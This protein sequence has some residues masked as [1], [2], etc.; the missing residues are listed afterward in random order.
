M[1]QAFH[2][3][4]NE[5]TMFESG[6]F[7][8]AAQKISARIDE[9]R[10]ALAAHNIEPDRNVFAAR[11][12]GVHHA[13]LTDVLSHVDMLKG[14]VLNIH[15]VL[16]NQ[17]VFKQGEG[18]Q[19]HYVLDADQAIEVLSV[20]DDYVTM[21]DDV[22]AYAKGMNLRG[23]DKQMF[24]DRAYHQYQPKEDGVIKFVASHVKRE[25]QPKV[26]AAFAQDS[27]LSDLN[28]HAADMFAEE[29][30]SAAGDPLELT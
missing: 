16:W 19:S 1:D 17:A 25:D 22:R 10:A 4:A 9:T 24:E 3:S 11:T 6:E 8:V 29:L 26:L 18:S 27:R 14:H 15:V 28:M 12:Q 2:S 23:R 5:K 7:E 13:S 30:D 20:L 21:M